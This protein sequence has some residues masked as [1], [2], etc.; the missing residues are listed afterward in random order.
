MASRRRSIFV[1]CQGTRGDVQPYVLVGLGLQR[2]GW[3]VLLGAPGEFREFVASAGLQFRDIGAAPT[4]AM[5]AA[6]AAAG[7]RQRPF[8]ALRA[9]RALFDPPGGEPFAAPWFAAILDGAR[10]LQPDVLLLVFTS[11]CG[12]AAIPQLLG[13]PTRVVLSYPM[14]MAPTAEFMPAMAGAGY[15]ACLGALNR[16]AWALSERAVVQGVHLGAA[17]RILAGAVAREAAAR[18][19]LPGAAA[20]ALDERMNAGALPT[21]FLWSPALLPRPADWPENHRV[22]G[23][24]RSPPGSAPPRPL[25]APLQAFLDAAAADKVPVVYV[26]FGSLGFFPPAHVTEILDACAE[27]VVKLSAERGGALRAVVQT[28]L[29]STPGRTCALSAAAAADPSILAFSESVDH[30]S[31]FRQCALVVSHGGVGTVQAA[32]AAGRP[33]LSV[34]CLPTSDQSFWADLCARRQLGPDWLWVQ[35]LT[36]ARLRDRLKDGLDNLERYA[37]NAAL[38]AAA[39]A[40]EDGVGAAVRAL[41]AEAAAARA[42]AAA[43]APAM[44]AAAVALKPSPFAATP[45]RVTVAA[46]PAAA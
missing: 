24:P 43:A 10:E 33:V 16:A 22:L 5:Y 1:A 45:V 11:W 35:Y 38:L 29:S 37:G 12:A 32:L 26:G 40:A 23:A 25:P 13:L 42:G 36:A 9:G 7:G 19:P 3:D 4:H 41:N 46:G 39:M 30:A 8:A 31:L 28:A 21:L 20:V 14:P 6:A 44:Q 2:D 18:R 15:T 17:R 27:A 34:C